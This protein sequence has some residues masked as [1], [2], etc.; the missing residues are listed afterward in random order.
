MASE[1]VGSGVVIH[2]GMAFQVELQS[3]TLTASI[4]FHHCADTKV[5]T[6]VIFLSS[7]PYYSCR[8]TSGPTINE[9]D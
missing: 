2:M 6:V 3:H 7:N 4:L 8:T 5:T 9:I 1:S